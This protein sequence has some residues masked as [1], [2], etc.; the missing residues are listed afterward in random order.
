MNKGSERPLM[1][2]ESHRIFSIEILIQ[3]VFYNQVICKTVIRKANPLTPPVIYPEYIFRVLPPV[4]K[5]TKLNGV[6]IN[7]AIM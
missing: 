6:K 4:R 1:L 3:E 5:P 7:Q 2:K